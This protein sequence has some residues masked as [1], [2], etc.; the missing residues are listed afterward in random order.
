MLAN[1]TIDLCAPV[2]AARLTVNSEL[3]SLVLALSTSSAE[4]R[5]ALVVGVRRCDHGVVS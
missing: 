2:Q 5:T 3:M 1:C 4:V